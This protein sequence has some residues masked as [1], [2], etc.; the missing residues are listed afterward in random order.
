MKK[1][2]II[3]SNRDFNNIIKKNKA[4][5][6]KYYIIYVEK[7]DSSVYKFGFSV[8]KKIGNAV[9]RNKIKR[10]LKN[11]IDKKDYKNN[12]NCI[13]IVSKE[14]LLKTYDQMNK[15][16]I[17]ALEKLNLIKENINE[18]KNNSIS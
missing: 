1:I 15:D 11:I 4:F 8:G 14:I 6:F 17:E 18:E 2:N 7:K 12:F 5:K 9:T 16:L 3:K 10:R 13:I